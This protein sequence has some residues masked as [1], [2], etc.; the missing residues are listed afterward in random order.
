MTCKVELLGFMLTVN[1]K[2]PTTYIPKPCTQQHITHA[3]L[4]KK[5]NTQGF[6]YT[7]ENTHLETFLINAE[8]KVRANMVF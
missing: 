4:P 2:N 5:T 7:F 3:R 8:P 6:L 1:F